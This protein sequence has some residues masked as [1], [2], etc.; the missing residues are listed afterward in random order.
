MQLPAQRERPAGLHAGAPR[1][2]VS[3]IARCVQLV[4][5]DMVAAESHLASLV[6]ST[7]PA[8]DEIAR[9]L[10]D[11]G[12]KRLRPLLTALAARAAGNHGEVARLMCAGEILHLGSLLH[13]D[14]V[15]D[16][17]ERR[18]LPTAHR[19]YGNPAV[20]LTG[21]VCLARAV[22]IAGQEAGQHATLEMA[23]V[24]TAMAEGEVLQLVHA[25]DLDLPLDTYLDII[26]RKS[27]E[28]ISWCAAAGA[29]AIGA[30]AEARALQEFGRSV[31]VAFQIS[32]DVLD[33]TSSLEVMGKRAGK[34][35]E[36]RKLTLPLLFAC[37][38][39][40]QLAADLRAGPPPAEAVPAL[41][42][43]VIA[44]GGPA[45]ALEHARTRV[46]AGV[47]AL[48]ALPDTPYRA[49]LVELAAHLVDR[50]S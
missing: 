24:V 42:Q 29:W 3:P 17:Q 38:A 4:Q 46:D 31:G 27:A 6:S 49:A 41:V 21:D 32:D 45:R 36:E 14:V 35:L 28:L 9:Y 20:I 44:T 2:R 18:G 11:A 37:E 40:P 13:D 26:D 34:D 43:S 15:D 19:V 16:G 12:G 33:Y 7:V 5:A 8:V 25:G 22:L 39:D 48:D 50:V 10:A 30:D 23:R 47:R 1:T